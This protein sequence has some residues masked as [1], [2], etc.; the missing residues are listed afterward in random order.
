MMP[1]IENLSWGAKSQQGKPRVP[2]FTAGQDKAGKL[3]YI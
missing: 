1:S 3:V 2:N